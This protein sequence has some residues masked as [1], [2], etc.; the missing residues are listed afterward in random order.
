MDMKKFID[1]ALCKPEEGDTIEYFNLKGRAAGNVLTNATGIPAGGYNYEADITKFWAE[2]KKLKA[3]VDYPLSFN[4]L[5]LRVLAE[6]LKVAPRLNSHLEYKE[7]SSCGRLI[8]KKHID[9]AVPIFMESGET[10]PVKLRHL[11]EKN[12]KEIYEEM[13]RLLT[14]LKTTDVDSVLF[15]VIAQRI[16][17]F[18]LK[19]KIGTAISMAAS[20]YIGK[21]KVAKISG[22]FKHADRDPEKSLQPYELNEGTVCLTNLGSISAGLPGNVTYAPLLYPQSFIMAIGSVQDRDFAFKNE[23][24]VVDIATK[25]ILPINIMFDH[26]I[27]GFGDVVPFLKKINEIFEN[28]EII[29]NW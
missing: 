21:Y 22:L 15:D 20:G 17:G 23:E 4:T 3:E 19:G 14:V 18:V 27:G 24:G 26:R 2:F 7:K 8:V 5:M 25:K 16:V 28:P 10:F 13:N 29:R 6:G 12:L 11:E 9:V 1:T